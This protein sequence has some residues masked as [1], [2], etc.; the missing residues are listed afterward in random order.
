M[1]K[2]SIRWFLPILLCLLL[3][4]VTA[5]ASESGSLRIVDVEKTVALYPVA[6]YDGSL[7]EVFQNAPVEDILEES[8]AV[9]N[10]A[11][12]DQF[13]KENQISGQEQVPDENKEVYYAALETGVYL[14]RS[15]Q[16]EPEFT[17][18]LVCIPTRI[19]KELIYDVKA[20]PKAQE[21]TEPTEPTTPTEPTEPE[22]EIPQTGT[23]ILPQ[24]ILL[25]IG[26]VA[27]VLGFTEM[28]RGREKQL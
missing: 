23:S 1:R 8:K 3:G 2:F 15:M 11:V 24:Y 28:I 16:S 25:G 22:P 18:F 26:I 10:A 13:V 21:P 27:L 20:E 9:E 4:C 12:L 14:V 17:P 6:T 19:N 7:T 5:S